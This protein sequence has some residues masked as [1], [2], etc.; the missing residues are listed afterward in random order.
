MWIGAAARSSRK[1]CLL[2]PKCRVNAT[3]KVGAKRG[4]SSIFCEEAKE[5]TSAGL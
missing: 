5:W 2:G 1:L 4:Y 3:G